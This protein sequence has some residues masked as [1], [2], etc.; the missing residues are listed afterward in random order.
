MTDSKITK[1]EIEKI[2][3]LSRIELESDEV[4]KYQPELS[5]ILETSSVIEELNT[6]NVEI[7]AQVTGL[8]NVLREDEA[9]ESLSQK[10]A[11]LNAPRNSRGHFVVKKVL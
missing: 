5:N 6:I 8:T 3:S 4:D 1:K 7:T 10:D 11:L 2:A 9:G